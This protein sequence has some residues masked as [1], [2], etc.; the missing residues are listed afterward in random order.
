MNSLEKVIKNDLCIGCG[1]CAVMSESAGMELKGGLYAPNFQN[2]TISQQTS[3]DAVCPF[4]DLSSNED[5]IAR[6]VFEI[7]QLKK[8]D[9]LGYWHSAYAGYSVEM[10][11]YGASGGIIS[12]LL[13]K[14][15]EDDL[16][17]YVIAVGEIGNQH[18]RFGY[19]II[20]SVDELKI[21]GGSAY[22]PVTYSEVIEQV[23]QQEGR[24]V[25]V[26]IPCFNKSIR[27]LKKQDPVLDRRIVFQ[28]GL[29]CGHLKTKEYGDYLIR[30]TGLHEDNVKSIHFRRKAEDGKA[31]EYLFE[32]K[33]ADG[34]VRTISNKQIGSNWGMGVFKPKACD[35]CDDVFA[36]T[37]DA[38][39]MDAWLPQYIK[40]G[41]G[42]SL[43]LTRTEKLDALVRAHIESGELIAEEVN[44]QELVDSQAGGI[45]H[46]R[47]GLKFRLFIAGIFGWK[48]TKR[49]MPT[50]KVGFWFALVQ[51]ARLFLRRLSK[52]T[53]S[54]QKRSRGTNFYTAVMLFPKF[55]FKVISKIYR[56]FDKNPRLT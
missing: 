19:K 27:L 9:Y 53:F 10:R 48:P 15:L 38:V 16:V 52:F 24:Y 7:T 25:F 12:W 32:A 41:K 56:K 55:V 42:I 39:C 34:E 40:D 21:S 28:V 47:R 5:Q 35:Y 11:E 17:D 29:V 8:D 4:T 36:E 33:T 18:P 22:Y 2:S 54:I 20:S 46:R 43:F 31:N 26:G 30:L 45:R 51:V 37:A 14:L 23:R 50:A 44:E 13:A 6:E 49:V 3:A 1:A